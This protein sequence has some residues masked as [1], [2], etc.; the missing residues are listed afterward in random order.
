MSNAH[1]RKNRLEMP[2]IES[3]FAERR[4]L[5]WMRPDAQRFLRPDSERYL[6]P[7]ARALDTKARCALA[8]DPSRQ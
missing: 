2:F 6:R 7:S 3:A 1:S 5:R 8:F 4:R